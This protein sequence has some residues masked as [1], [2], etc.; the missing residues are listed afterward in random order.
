MEHLSLSS[1]A[2]AALREFA[3]AKGCDIESDEENE[4]FLNKVQSHFDI[5][6]KTDQFEF[7]FG[8]G[9]DQIRFKLDGLKREIGQTLSSTGLTL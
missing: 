6:D 7:E 8:Q 9:K 2:L 5:K 4:N 3:L 1:E